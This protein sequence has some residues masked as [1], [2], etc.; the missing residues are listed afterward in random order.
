MIVIIQTLAKAKLISQSLYSGP[1]WFFAFSSISVLIWIP[2][3]LISIA[4]PAYTK[5][6]SS[7]KNRIFAAGFDTWEA[8]YPY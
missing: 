7:K 5:V 4:G 1:L 2:M 8:L 3:Q 6:L